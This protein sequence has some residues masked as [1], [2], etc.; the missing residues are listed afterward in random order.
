MKR[1]LRGLWTVVLYLILA[2]TLMGKDVRQLFEPEPVIMLLGGGV[3]L[4]LPHLQKGVKWRQMKEI[5]GQS[6]L[7]AGY[8]EA[9]MMIFM[10][11]HQYDWTQG[12]LW[13]DLMLDLRP[14]IYGFACYL[15]CRKNED[16]KQK[17]EIRTLQEKEGADLSVLTKREKQ[18]A[19]LI[20]RG[21]SNR[22]IGEELYISETTV[23]KHVSHIFEKLGIESRKDLM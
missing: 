4:C 16:S 9:G 19:E 1:K 10:R 23:K 21:C 5:F 11:L 15:I 13:N 20:K 17:E 18:V 14:V 6:A 2:G 8:L 3:I 12:R 7:M 22:E